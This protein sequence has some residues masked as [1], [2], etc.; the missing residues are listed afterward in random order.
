[1]A[2]AAVGVAIFADRGYRR[3]I[4]APAA[5]QEKLASRLADQIKDAEDTVFRNAN[6]IDQLLALEQYSLPYDKELARARYQEWLLALVK[7]TKL[8][9]PSVD[10]NPPTTISI[11]VRGTSRRREVYQ[12]YVF[13]VRGRGTLGQVTQLLFEFYQGGHLHKIRSLSLNPASGGNQLDV[14]MSI[15]AIGLARCERESELSTLQ[16]HRLAKADLRDYQAI[17]RR[18]IFS[19][20]GGAVLRNTILTAVTVDRNGKMGAWFSLGDKTQTQVAHHQVVII[21]IQTKAVVI[22]VDGTVLRL[23]LGKS[24]FELLEPMVEPENTVSGSR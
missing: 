13:S 20:E 12:R 7:K 19:Q 23:P 21:D 3:F 9:Q 5:A 8:Q 11:R 16:G 4:V 22:E 2:L 1:M 24:I 14:T 18:N 17:V 15:E 10:S 6:V